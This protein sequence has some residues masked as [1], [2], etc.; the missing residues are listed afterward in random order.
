MTPVIVIG[1][2]ENIYTPN[3]RKRLQ[4]EF[5]QHSYRHMIARLS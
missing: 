4:Y 2:Q 1:G 5:P 3:I